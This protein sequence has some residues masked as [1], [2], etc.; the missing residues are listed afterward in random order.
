MPNN[1]KRV[2]LSI[3]FSDGLSDNRKRRDVTLAFNPEDNIYQKCK[4]MGSLKIREIIGTN[5]YIELTD[6]A[7]REDRSVSNYMKHVLREYFKNE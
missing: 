6:R 5:S 1:R 7:K 3:Y 4:G 2:F